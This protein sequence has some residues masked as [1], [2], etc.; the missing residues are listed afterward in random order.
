MVRAM[1]KQSNDN[2]PEDVFNEDNW[3]KDEQSKTPCIVAKN[4]TQRRNKG[5]KT[6]EQWKENYR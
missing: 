4:I 3:M 5:D 2:A 1:S 6:K